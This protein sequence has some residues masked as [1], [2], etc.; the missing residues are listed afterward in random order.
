MRPR[1]CHNE[2]SVGHCRHYGG[3][4]YCHLR[5]FLT[6]AV[7]GTGELP[8]LRHKISKHI[9]FHLPEPARPDLFLHVAQTDTFHHNGSSRTPLLKCGAGVFPTK[10]QRYH[11]A[12]DV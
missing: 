7:T 3:R 9:C 10:V 12:A 5:W 11:A 2:V 4:F 6:H 1:L 8:Q